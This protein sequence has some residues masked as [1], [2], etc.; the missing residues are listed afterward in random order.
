MRVPP[1]RPCAH[2]VTLFMLTHGILYE[3]RDREKE[4]ER[5]RKSERRESMPLAI[6]GYSIILSYFLSKFTSHKMI[7]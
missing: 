1:S 7:G 5:E 2:D 6:F 4:R 3:R